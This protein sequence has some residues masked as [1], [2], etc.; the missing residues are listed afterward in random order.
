[1]RL[2]NKVILKHSNQA[3]KGSLVSIV[4]CQDEFREV[5]MNSFFFLI[6]LRLFETGF[7]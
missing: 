6:L 3:V 2:V 7:L 5:L 1:M 4:E